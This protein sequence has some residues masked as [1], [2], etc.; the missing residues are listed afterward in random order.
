MSVGI[1][2][3]IFRMTTVTLGALILVAQALAPSGGIAIADVADTA[4]PP[5]ASC[6]AQVLPPQ[7]LAPRGNVRIM[8]PADA[9]RVPCRPDFA[10]EVS[11][12]R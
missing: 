5:D 9:L 4:R 1:Q 11:S 7:I 2:T 10:G 6:A 8:S 12:V 3:V